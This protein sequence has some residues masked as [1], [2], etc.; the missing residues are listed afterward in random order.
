MNAVLQPDLLTATAAVSEPQTLE[1][2]EPASH[3]IAKP[4]AAP[5]QNLAES[6]PAAIMLRALER[7]VSPA[8]VRE[9]M[10]IHR[11]WEADEARKAFNDSLAAFKGEA[12]ELVKRKLVSFTTRDGDTTSYRHAELSDVVDA[13]GPA[14]SR[15]GFSWRWDITQ[16]NGT[17]SVTCIL[18][19]AKGHSEQVTMSAPPD[20]S[21]KKN[22]IQQIAS[23]VSYLERYTLKAITGVAERGDDDDGTNAGSREDDALAGTA[24]ALL[25]SLL[26]RLENCA[27]DEKAAELWA[28]GSHALA[29][30]KQAELYA[31]FKEAVLKHRRA[32]KSKG[33]VQ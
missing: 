19:H 17:V 5:A 28:E 18:K 8:D 1:L 32:L 33:G 10:A 30:A 27:T 22:G 21:G 25:D 4:A 15:H 20:A 24:A 7:G 3:Q 31:T 16:A 23:T 14:L 6:S 26:A 13:V 9:M 29:D 2:V 11:E 12:V